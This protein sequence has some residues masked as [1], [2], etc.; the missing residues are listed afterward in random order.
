MS[1]LEMKQTNVIQMPCAQTMKD[2]MSVAAKG[3]ILEMEKNVQVK[4]AVQ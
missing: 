3:D 1:A 2:L 4:K